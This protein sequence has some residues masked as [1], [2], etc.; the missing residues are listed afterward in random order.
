[1]QK[2]AFTALY[3]ILRSTRFLLQHYESRAGALPAVRDVQQAINRALK[4]IDEVL[5][6]QAAD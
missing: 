3:E 1:M 5:H 4:Q 2:Q 6:K